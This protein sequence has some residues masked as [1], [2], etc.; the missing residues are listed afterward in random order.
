MTKWILLALFAGCAS[1]TT[2][3]SWID[4]NGKRVF[5]DTPPASGKY[6]EME[7]V[8]PPPATPVPE[9]VAPESEEAVA[10][11]EDKEPPAPQVAAPPK[12]TLVSPRSN[13]TIRTNTG[14][15]TL[16]IETDKPLE[17]PYEVE[18][19]LDNAPFGPIVNDKQWTVSG[20]DNG[21]R[22][23]QIALLKNGEYIAYS[24]KVI[25]YIR[26]KANRPNPTPQPR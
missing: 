7:Y 4:S 17:D 6:E 23:L 16:I 22:T 8:A 9:V 15:I 3:Y 2:V 12:I 21:T 11:V 5:S 1:A 26:R 14:E 18:L 20:A 13:E 19:L 10:E 25:V 24:E